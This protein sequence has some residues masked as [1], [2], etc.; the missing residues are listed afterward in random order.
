MHVIRGSFSAESFRGK[1]KSLAQPAGVTSRSLDLKDRADWRLPSY[2]EQSYPS[3]LSTRR[4]SDGDAPC[5]ERGS[6][7]AASTVGR[8]TSSTWQTACNYRHTHTNA[9]PSYFMSSANECASAFS[10][11]CRYIGSTNAWS[12]AR[13]SVRR[14]P[15]WQGQAHQRR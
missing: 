7:T 3:T 11:V 6:P 1:E 5:V 15:F 14:A 9:C 2:I 13:M 10:C 8:S 12:A 4:N